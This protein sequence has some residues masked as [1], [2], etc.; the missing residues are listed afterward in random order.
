MRVGLDLRMIGNSGIGSYLKGLLAGFAEIDAPIEWTFVGPEVEVPAGL[1]IARWIDFD[2]APYS[3]A[4]FRSYPAIPQVD[5]F[6]YPHY[7]LPRIAVRRRVVTAYDTFH[8]AY[9]NL[10]RRSYQRFFL[11]RLAL[12]RTPVI[13]ISAESA[14][15]IRRRSL[16][17][18]RRIEVIDLGPGRIVEAGAAQRP[19]G[20]GSARSGVTLASGRKLEPP[21]F[22][23]V[24]IDQPH[25]NMNFLISAMA[26]WYRRRGDAPPL[27][28]VGMKP[29]LIDER[30]AAIPAHARERIH[31]LPYRADAEIETLYAGAQALLFPSMD[32]GFGL[33]P[34]EAMARGVP[35][36]A[37]R[38]RPMSDLLG[39]A[40]L[41]FDPR[42]S[43]S[44][45]RCCDRLLDERGLREEMIQRGRAVA[46][47]FSW[48]RTARET[49]QVYQR[50]VAQRA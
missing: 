33:P 24:G 17:A 12:T 50:T 32:E 30:K 21:W 3:L 1:C 20:M 5:L 46:A 15:E 13:T 40:P 45:W 43:S 29:E 14:A 34:L 27:I 18:S 11:T 23:A 38:R 49:L 16:I 41:W 25:K 22:L 9:G 19:A 44:L 35:V 48:Q 6:H 39:N 10:A 37:A 36:A 8:L 31:L 2:A 42:D 47:G 26:L 4:E 28:W 7:N